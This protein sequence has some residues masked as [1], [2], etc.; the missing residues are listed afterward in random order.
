MERG[1]E[2][3]GL[4]VNLKKTKVMVSASKGEILKSKVDPCAKCDKS[5]MTN[6]V[7]CTKCGKW[8]H[9]RCAKM[10]R[11]ASTLA[12]GFVCELCVYT[13]K[14]IMK[15]GEELSFFDQADF[16]KSSCNLGDRLN[17]SD[18]SEATVTVRTRIGWIKFRECGELLSG[19]KFSLK[20]KGRIYQSCVTSAMLYESET[21]S[22]REN[23]MAVLRRTEKAMMRAM[24]GVEMIE[25]RGSQEYMS[26][27]GL[28][29]TLDRLARA[30]GVRWYGPA[31]KRD[32]GD[33]L[34]RVLDLEVAG[35]RGR[36]RSN[37][38][39]KR[40]VE[41]HINQIGLKSKDIID[42][43][44]WRDGVYELSRSTE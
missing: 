13:K 43:E 44:K 42:R 7:M 27:L 19:R 31:L 17:A 14:G 4:K 21:W 26:L 40:P 38:S 15:P 1:F 36:G 12:K 39:W 11:V 33:A 41:E 22:L 29:D 30:S 3:K 9:G 25:K 28:T 6:S 16:V 10:K 32:N 8:V 37:M 35:R 5:V 20:M 24:C 18:G 23:E 2:S 34:R